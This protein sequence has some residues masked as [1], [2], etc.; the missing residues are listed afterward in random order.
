V[1]ER[2]I[3]PNLFI[4]GQKQSEF[5]NVCTSLLYAPYSFL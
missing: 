4:K 3:K 2:E 1:T 5:K